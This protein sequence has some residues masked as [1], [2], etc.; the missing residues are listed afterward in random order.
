MNRADFQKLSELRLNEAN[1]LLAANSYAGAYY[2]AGYSVEC[3]LKACI[4]KQTQQYD[5]PIKNSDKIYT[6]NLSNLLNL[7][8]LSEEHRK[9]SEKNEA[10]DANWTIVKDWKED[11]RYSLEITKDQADALYLAIADG[12]DGVMSWLQKCW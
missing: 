8:G 7:S 10:F 6:H 4:A 5:F 2:L 9:N 1:V 3:A 11:V 12:K